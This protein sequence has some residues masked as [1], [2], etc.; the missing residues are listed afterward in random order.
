MANDRGL[1]GVSVRSLLGAQATTVADVARAAASKAGSGA[2]EEGMHWRELLGLLA[3]S[4]SQ[5]VEA[6]C[7]GE[8]LAA[9]PSGIQQAQVEPILVC[10]GDGGCGCDGYRP[11]AM[12]MQAFAS[13]YVFDGLLGWPLE[14]V[15]PLPSMEEMAAQSVASA[16]GLE[17]RIQRYQLVGHSWGAMLALEIARQL[18]DA[19]ETVA[20][21]CLLDPSPEM[22]TEDQQAFESSALG[23]ATDS[24]LQSVLC[25]GREA[26][27]DTEEL[28]PSFQSALALSDLFQLLVRGG[29]KDLQE[30]L[31]L[32]L[33]ENDVVGAVQLAREKLDSAS[34]A[35]AQAVANARAHNLKMRPPHWPRFPRPLRARVLLV[36]AMDQETDEWAR[37]EK[38]AVLTN[39]LGQVAEDVT[40]V[41]TPGDHYSMLAPPHC[42]AL[43]RTIAS[44]MEPISATPEV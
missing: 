20:F 3:D 35:E 27:D 44:A 32:R 26:G 42:Q 7:L 39:A 22:F 41:W 4:G 31:Q 43:A 40:T 11:L 21:V 36:M 10:P 12:H 37:V 18:E 29:A 14:G 5:G 9:S 17:K 33:Q 2:T 1:P 15:P 24:W 30:E 25:M 23:L 13:T 19:G 38:R 6:R 16:R 28:A 34:F 8:K